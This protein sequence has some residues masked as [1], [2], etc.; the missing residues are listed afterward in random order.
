MTVA[1][2]A[3]LLQSAF[4]GTGT[5]ALAKLPLCDADVGGGGKTDMGTPVIG[6][7]VI[8]A[9]V[10]DDTEGYDAPVT[11]IGPVPDG[12]LRLDGNGGGVR[13]DEGGPPPANDG[14]GANGADGCVPDCI[15]GWLGLDW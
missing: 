10:I 14:A 1:I 6:A 9:P 15:P 7:A 8:G 4:D 5:I 2:A 12:E 3:R 11:E 13:C